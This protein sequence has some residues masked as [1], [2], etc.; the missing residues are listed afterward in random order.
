MNTSLS[1]S[2]DANYCFLWRVEWLTVALPSDTGVPGNWTTHTQLQGLDPLISNKRPSSTGF[3]F[4]S[5]FQDLTA[6][7]VTPPWG[8]QRFSK[9]LLFFERA[10]WVTFLQERSLARRVVPAPPG[11]FWKREMN[12][13]DQSGIISPSV[14]SGLNS[15]TQSSVYG[16]GAIIT[17]QFHL[18]YYY[19]ISCIC[20][21]LQQ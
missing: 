10:F 1:I 3:T 12:Q 14:C 9:K 7:W 15:S 18:F 11:R 13:S 6:F 21:I 16:P 2:E 8:S 5:S 19:H 4:N 17:E 20:F